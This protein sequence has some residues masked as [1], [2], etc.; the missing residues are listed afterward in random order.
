MTAYEFLYQEDLYQVSD[1][2]LVLID[3]PWEALREED[4]TLLAK[5]LGSVKLSIDQ[6]RIATARETSITVLEVYSPTKIISFGVKI[7]ESKDIYKNQQIGTT[8]L[9]LSDTLDQLD[10][11]RK[12]SLWVALKQMFA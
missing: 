10:D 2:V 12:K 11:V 9:I 6:V 4:K 5:I 1:S 3:R 7:S 8:S